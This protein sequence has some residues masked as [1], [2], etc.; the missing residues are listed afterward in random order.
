MILPSQIHKT[1]GVV[2]TLSG[3]SGVGKGTVISKVLE[4]SPEI[5]HS[6]SVT[7]RKPRNGEKHGVDYYFTDNE[8]FEKMIKH[9][10]ILRYDK[11]CNYY[12]R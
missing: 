11:T 7:T 12:G 6:V 8:S 3:P 4:L 10:E 9:D 2:I 1:K 5:K